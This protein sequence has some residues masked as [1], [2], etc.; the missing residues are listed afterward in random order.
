MG[1]GEQG[2]REVHSRCEIPGAARER[3]MRG[4]PVTNWRLELPWL[5]C[6]VLGP[7]PLKERGVYVGGR[8]WTVPLPPD[9]V[10]LHLVP[11]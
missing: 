4:A 2:S 6:G 7:R 10:L 8:M 5:I 11:C 9:P 1:K 3:R